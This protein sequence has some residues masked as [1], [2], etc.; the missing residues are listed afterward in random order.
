MLPPPP[1][2]ILSTQLEVDHDNG[3]LTAGDDEDDE[4]Q[5]QKTKHVVELILVDGGEYKEQLNEAGSKR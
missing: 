3:D 4:H 2:V 5:K 1:V